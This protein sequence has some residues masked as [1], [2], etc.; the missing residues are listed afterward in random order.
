MVQGV[1]EQPS[2]GHEVAGIALEAIEEAFFAWHETAEPHRCTSPPA[3][4]HCSTA[5]E[6]TVAAPVITR[7][8]RSGGGTQD[9]TGGHGAA[10]ARS[11]SPARWP[12]AARART[13]PGAAGPAGSVALA[14]AR[15]HVPRGAI[16]GGAGP[17]SGAP[18]EAVPEL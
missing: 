7:L 16:G 18:G 15:S 17:A 9:Y 10:S 13:P 4:R 8:T 11:R 12:G 5:L 2:A 1:H 14:V 6:T 3:C